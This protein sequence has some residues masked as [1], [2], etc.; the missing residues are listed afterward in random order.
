MAEELDLSDLF[1]V[2]EA[3]GEKKPTGRGGPGRGQGRKPKGYVKPV[4]IVDFEK[5][6][7]RNEAAKADN[8]ELDFKVKSGQFVDRDQVRQ[9]AAT[10][11]LSVA[12]TLRSIPDVLERNGH[13]AKVCE[14]VERVI[15]DTLASAAQD[16]EMLTGPVESATQ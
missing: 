6:R 2:P 10:I 3:A 15:N 5:A 12:Q 7:A 16:L 9:A 13:D 8:N 11:M 4:E 1:D 14:H